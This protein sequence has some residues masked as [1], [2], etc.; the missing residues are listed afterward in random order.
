MSLKIKYKN[1]S[2]KY[3]SIKLSTK[4]RFILIDKNNNNL[5]CDCGNALFAKNKNI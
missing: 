4:N 3:K 5:I 1:K 2:L